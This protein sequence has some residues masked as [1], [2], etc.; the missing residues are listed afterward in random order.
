MCLAICPA[1]RR[2]NGVHGG[3]VSNEQRAGRAAVVRP[4]QMLD[5]LS[6][7]RLGR[8]RRANP[9]KGRAM[10]KTLTRI[11]LTLALIG[12]VIP[13][14]GCQL[15][16]DR[17]DSSFSDSVFDFAFDF[18]SFDFVDSFFVHEG[19]IDELDDIQSDDP[20]EAGAHAD[21]TC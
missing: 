13:T 4:V 10:R 19:S 8:A 20:L 15:R 2:W 12:L 6:R 18:G 1:G 9:R 3:A 11:V 7:R 5:A 16:R 14:A 17:R 21:S